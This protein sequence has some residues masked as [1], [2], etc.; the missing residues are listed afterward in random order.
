MVYTTTLLFVIGSI[1]I[2]GG[3]TVPL[4]KLLDIEMLR[5]SAD[6][7]GGHDDEDTT[8]EVQGLIEKWE[9]T[10]I[11]DPFLKTAEQRD[12]GRATV[13]HSACCLSSDGI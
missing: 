7:Q 9:K 3:A 12:R 13:V 6:Q 4:I 10:Y 1:F 8:L 5:D 11:I 2:F